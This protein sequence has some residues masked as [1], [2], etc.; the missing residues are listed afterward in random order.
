MKDDGTID[1]L[2]SR[3]LSGIGGDLG[4]AFSQP[5]EEMNNNFLDEYQLGMMDIGGPFVIHFAVMFLCIFGALLSGQY[6]YKKE[7]GRYKEGN[8]MY[9][10]GKMVAESWCELPTFQ[11]FRSSTYMVFRG[12]SKKASDKTSVRSSTSE[13][14]SVSAHGASRKATS[15]L[16]KIQEALREEFNDIFNDEEENENAVQKM[17]GTNQDLKELT[18]QLLLIRDVLI[19]SSEVIISE[20][21]EIEIKMAC[22]T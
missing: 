14:N 5:L 12:S 11:N 20:K 1:R 13:S 10:M 3:H 15:E 21:E 22:E 9:S 6:R 2:M 19:D 17:L 7:H 16:E 8:I 4:C 18:A